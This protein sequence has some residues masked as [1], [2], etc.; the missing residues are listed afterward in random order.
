MTTVTGS[1]PDVRPYLAAASLAV[2]QLRVARGVQNKILEAMAAGRAVIASPAAVEGLEVSAGADLLQ[3]DTPGEWV[4]QIRGLLADT[5]RRQA[6][7]RSAR[8]RVESAYTWPARL[9]PLVSL[10][11]AAGEPPVDRPSPGGSNTGCP[12]VVA[13]RPPAGSAGLTQATGGPAR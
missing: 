3:A 11:L 4:E 13:S 9:R 7:Q 10:A 2:V 6:V 5:S 12:A 8:S 1:V